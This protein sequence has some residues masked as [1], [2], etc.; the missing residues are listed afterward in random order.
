M[1][2]HHAVAV[3]W[4]DED[5]LGHVNNS[6]Y[7][8][9]TEDARLSWLADSP[10]GSGAVILAHT[11]IDF[12]QPLHFAVGG[13]L[14]VQTSVVR[15]GRSSVRLYQDIF[16]DTFDRVLGDARD[17]A[18]DG[19]APAVLDRAEA[20]ART[21]HVLV[22]YDY[23]TGRTRPWREPELSWLRRWTVEP[24]GEQAS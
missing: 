18:V 14:L 1:L 6:R 16:E 22:C 5:R 13:R 11:E 7:L 23:A 21:E 17:G 3:R 24:V 9:F 2:H 20:V 8:T 4:S 15:V 19:A 10:A 12:L